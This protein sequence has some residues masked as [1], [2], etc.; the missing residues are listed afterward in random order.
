M[1]TPVE[2]MMMMMLVMIMQFNIQHTHNTRHRRRKVQNRA[3]C[4]TECC[5]MWPWGFVFVNNW[6]LV[7]LTAFPSRACAR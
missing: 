5:Y 2:Q 1:G 4:R 7:G 6:A 3:Q